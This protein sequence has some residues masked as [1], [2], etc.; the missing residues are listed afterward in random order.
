MTQKPSNA[1]ETW[2]LKERGITPE[3]LERCKVVTSDTEARWKV[4]PREKIRTGFHPGQERKFRYSEKGEFD[5]WYLPVKSREIVDPVIA[6]EGETD[7]KRLWQD[8]GAQLYGQICA[9]PGCDAITPQAA[10]RLQKRAGKAD[11]YFVL[12]ND[13]TE[14]PAYNPDDWKDAKNPVRQVDE[15]W[16]R[17]KSLLP[18]ARRIYLPP[19]YKDLCEYLNIYTVKDFNEFVLNAEA[20]YNFEALDLSSP[21]EHPEYLWEDVIPRG[22]FVLLQGESNVGKS[23]LYQ[24][25]AVALANG[26]ERFLDRRLNP[27]REGR[28]LIVD[29][30]NPEE[31]VRHRLHQLGLKP[32]A[33]KKLRIIS[34]RGVRIDLDSDRLFED[35]SNF[36]PDLTV[37]DSFI[38]LHSEDENS[39][40]AVSGMFNKSVLPISRQL[41][42][43]VLLLHHVNR[44]DSGDSRRRTRGSTD[45]MASTDV[46]WDMLDQEGEVKYKHLS[47]FKTRSGRVSKDLRF[48]IE[49][50]AGGRLE[51]PLLNAGADAL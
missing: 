42:S 39:A 15:S 7:A 51:F 26:E 20:R 45:I 4:G 12:D 16:K 47:R 23:L 43:A 44:T 33:Q 36:N 6:C 9:M 13:K 21:A 32:H 25:L 1:V 50:T 29:E 28:V 48:R 14:E 30:E 5:F 38:R 34:Q 22:Q 3:T 24:A 2:Y 17:I 10:A 46:A 11:I 40:S 37:L 19:D 35:V 49:D 18:K 27:E 8:G 41:G 31:V